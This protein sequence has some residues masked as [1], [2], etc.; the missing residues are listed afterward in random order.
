MRQIYKHKI[1]GAFLELKNKYEN[2]A[3][4]YLLDKN[5]SRT[6]SLFYWHNIVNTCVCKLTNVY[7]LDIKN[8]LTTEKIQGIQGNL[9]ECVA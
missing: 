7:K 2:V 4:F 3:S 8:N 1:T 9:L 5:F 6:E